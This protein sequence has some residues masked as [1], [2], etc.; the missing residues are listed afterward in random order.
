MLIKNQLEQTD[1]DHLGKLLIY[2]VGLQAVIVVWLADRFRD[3]HRAILNWLNE[4]TH[5]DSRYC[6]CIRRHGSFKQPAT[7]LWSLQFGER[8]SRAG[9]P[10]CQTGGVGRALAEPRTRS[11][12]SMV[13]LAHAF[14]SGNRLACLPGRD[15][16]LEHVVKTIFGLIATQFTGLVL[17]PL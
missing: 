5:Q 9:I 3:E 17:E 6:P 10:D 7:D 1:H 15:Y 4:I 11:H 13:K 14:R 16:L 8:G 2:A 12:S